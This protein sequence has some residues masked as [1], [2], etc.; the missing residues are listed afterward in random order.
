MIDN[1][2]YTFGFTAASMRLNDFVMIARNLHNGQYID[3]I[4]LLGA[5]KE[6]TG[7]R[8]F[9]EYK[10]RIS[11]LT[12]DQLD[13]LINGSLPSQKQVAF[14]AICKTNGFIRDFVVEV[15]REKLLLFDYKLSDGDF[16]SYLRRKSAIHPELESITETTIRKI[17]QVSFKILEQAG[18]IESLKNKIIQ[19]Q[20]IDKDVMDA[21]VTDN[22]EWLKI[23]LLSDTD[24]NNA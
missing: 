18:I 10:K 21:L 5:G 13:I 8:L 14:L 22:K 1:E 2:K 4:N 11:N 24:I 19:P 6:A 15:V 3:Y 7:K 12:A 23:L 20:L 17:K 9:S 16:I